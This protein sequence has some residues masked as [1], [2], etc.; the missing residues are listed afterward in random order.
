MHVFLSY[1]RSDDQIV[2]PLS[3]LLCAVGI[4]PWLDTTGLPPGTLQWDHMIRHALRDAHAVIAVCSENARES[5]YVAIELEIAKG[6]GKRIF[7]VWVSGEEWSQ[8]A[9]VGLVLSQ[10][11]DL[12]PSKRQEGAEELITSVKRHLA[13]LPTMDAA[14]ADRWPLIRVT[15][16]NRYVDVNP[17]VHNDW[18]ELLSEVY[19]KLVRE[20]FAPFSYGETWVLEISASEDP[21]AFWGWPLFALPADW[22]ATPYRGVHEVSPAWVHS[23]PDFELSSIIQHGKERRGRGQ[24]QAEHLVRAEARV[25]ELSTLQQR[26]ATGMRGLRD[27]PWDNEN[28]QHNFIGLRSRCRTFWCFASGAHPKMTLMRLSGSDRTK[29]GCAEAFAFFGL[30][31]PRF[32]AVTIQ[33]EYFEHLMM[34]RLNRPAVQWN[35]NIIEFE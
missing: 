18:G 24:V 10:H 11:I 28:P 4:R 16:R 7:P 23:S 31:E 22:V 35:E 6:Y 27:R 34:R 14:M 19:L 15:W 21:F 17:F 12:R 30:D 29:D 26:A 20:D 25:I 3:A 8:S 13:S 32:E 9:S 5:Q 33:T 1:A 2:Q